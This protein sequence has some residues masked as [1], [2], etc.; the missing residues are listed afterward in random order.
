MHIIYN[1]IVLSSTKLQVSQHSSSSNLS[2]RT[3]CV[4]TGTVCA[5]QCT[6]IILCVYVSVWEDFLTINH[7]LSFNSAPVVLLA[8][9]RTDSQTPRLHLQPQQ[10]C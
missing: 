2:Q 5:V 6:Y 10:V 3:E 7:I 8:E 1:Y 4:I 9:V